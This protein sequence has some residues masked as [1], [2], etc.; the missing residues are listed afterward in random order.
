MARHR[1]D[2]VLSSPPSSR[3]STAG[4]NRT[5][6]AIAGLGSGSRVRPERVIGPRFARTRWGALDDGQRTSTIVVRPS[7]D[8]SRP[9]S[10]SQFGYAGARLAPTPRMRFDR[11]LF[12]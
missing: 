9:L 4:A 5:P 2:L 10:S 7:C 1:P 3:G 12:G 11:R 6:A 8:A